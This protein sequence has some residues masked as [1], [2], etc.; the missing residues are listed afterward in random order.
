MGPERVI[1]MAAA[2][3]PDGFARIEDVIPLAELEAIAAQYRQVA[4]F[5]RPA[6]GAA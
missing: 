2:R 5:Q 1:D 3:A 4:G 6:T